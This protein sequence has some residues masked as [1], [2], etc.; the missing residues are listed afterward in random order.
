MV[1]SC[2][3]RG[4]C[5]RSVG[6]IDVVID[7]VPHRYLSLRLLLPLLL[8]S[9]VH[10]GFVWDQTVAGGDNLVMLSLRSQVLMTVRQQLTDDVL[11]PWVQLDQLQLLH[12]IQHL[13]RV[14]QVESLPAR[15]LSTYF[16]DG[17]EGHARALILLFDRVCST[18]LHIEE[19]GL[20]VEPDAM[21]EVET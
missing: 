4:D 5:I 17:A 6:P 20:E 2:V 8:V 10:L 16:C 18:R 14:G 19:H 15:S 9:R 11:H 3:G 21:A 12:Q 1:T 7:E 13:F